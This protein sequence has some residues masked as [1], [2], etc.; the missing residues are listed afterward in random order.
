MHMKTNIP[1]RKVGVGGAVG[2]LVS[3]V[4]LLVNQYALPHNPIPAEAGA[5]LTTVL[6]FAASYFTPPSEQDTPVGPS[7][8]PAGRAPTHRSL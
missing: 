3:V 7:D 5:L 6:T 1:T 4:L 8:P 2:A